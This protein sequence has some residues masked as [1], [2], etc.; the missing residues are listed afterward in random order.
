MN[1]HIN[2]SLRQGSTDNEKDSIRPPQA[3]SLSFLLPQYDVS[4]LDS[5]NVQ[6]VHLF[7]AT[8]LLL[9]LAVSFRDNNLGCS[10]PHC[11]VVSR[12]TY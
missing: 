7:L 3:A 12:Y 9:S 11:F 6:K 1:R 4:V 8:T 10:C 2:N 5:K